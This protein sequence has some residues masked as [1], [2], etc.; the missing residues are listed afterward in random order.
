MDGYVVDV[1]GYGYV[2]LG[3][4]ERW[5]VVIGIIDLISVHSDF[6]VI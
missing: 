5:L 1:N 2:E 6:C 3:C 4:K